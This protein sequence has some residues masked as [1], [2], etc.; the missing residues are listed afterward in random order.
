M[1]ASLTLN[2]I[3]AQKGI[4]VG[5]AANR[6]R[7]SGLDA[8]LRSG[9]DDLPDGLQDLEGAARPDEAGAAFLL[10][11]AGREGQSR[12][13]RARCGACAATCSAMWS[14]AGSSG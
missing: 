7:R 2:K 3:T 4:S 12:L 11:D 13:R 5:E 14:R 9:G 10:P 6:S 1:T 8:E